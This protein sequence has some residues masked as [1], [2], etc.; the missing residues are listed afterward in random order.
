[1]FSAEYFPSWIQKHLTVSW[2]IECGLYSWYFILPTPD[3]R[4]QELQPGERGHCLGGGEDAGNRVL[5][6]RHGARLVGPAALQIDHHL[7]V[8]VD[9]EQGAEVFTRLELGC[10]QLAQ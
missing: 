5:G 3:A 10:E 4:E 1:M 8:D 9:G 7:A 2:R 6:P